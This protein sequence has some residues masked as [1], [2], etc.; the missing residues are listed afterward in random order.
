MAYNVFHP[1]THQGGKWL[2]RSVPR[3]KQG[4]FSDGKKTL[5][6]IFNVLFK[7]GQSKGSLKTALPWV[8]ETEH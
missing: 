6:G 4:H 8:L 3:M 7:V 2:L 5:V 1:G